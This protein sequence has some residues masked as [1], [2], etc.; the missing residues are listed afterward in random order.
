[1][2]VF[3][4]LS[5]CCACGTQG[6]ADHTWPPYTS[7]PALASGDVDGDGF[8]DLFALSDTRT[9]EVLGGVDIGPHP[10]PIG[11]YS[12]A[13]DARG[14]ARA[15][16]VVTSSARDVLV[17]ARSRD[18]IGMLDIEVRRD[19]GLVKTSAFSIPFDGTEVWL[20]SGQ[21]LVL[22]GAGGTVWLID[23]ADLQSSKPSPI[24]IPPPIG[25]WGRTKLAMAYALGADRFIVVSSDTAAFRARLPEDWSSFA[26]EP[27][28]Q[29]V[30]WLGQT[31]VDINRDGR[32]ELV[33]LDAGAPPNLCS[34]ELETQA[35]RCIRMTSNETYADVT[36]LG[37]SFDALTRTDF[38]V[39]HSRPTGQDYDVFGD[40]RFG[41]TTLTLAATTAGTPVFT[42]GTSPIYLIPIF[43]PERPTPWVVQLDS[44]GLF[45][46][47]YRIVNG[48]V[49]SC[50]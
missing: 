26:W 5:V 42:Q 41:S 27:I 40:V 29:G 44:S 30:A 49:Q 35:V 19:V 13:F 21:G 18:D 33:G 3:A 47:C 43:E 15:A 50:P 8:T 32:P 14:A 24:E 37:G 45:G 1:M 2:R 16:I 38:L 10:A 46:Y 31:A 20:S 23:A 12:E 39:V 11:S 6:S 48:D 36:I 7:L 9:Y 22:I 28:R 4:I 34:L 17:T 25:G